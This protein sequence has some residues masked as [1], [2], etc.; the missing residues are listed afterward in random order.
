MARAI[1]ATS[2]RLALADFVEGDIQAVHAYA[3][4]PL[5]SQYSPWGPNSLEESEQF[6]ADA[7]LKRDGRFLLAVCFEGNVIGSASVWVTDESQ[8]IGELGY[9][10]HQKFWGQGLGTEVAGMLV[11]LG[12]DVLGLSRIMATCDARNIGSRRVLEKAGLTL[13]GRIAED[14]PLIKGR[15]ETLVF[16]VETETKGWPPT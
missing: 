3:S 14:E 15:N 6:L 1:R 7:C 5:V 11:H 4:D 10:L 16:A 2:S 9:T 8:Q 12:T 13:V